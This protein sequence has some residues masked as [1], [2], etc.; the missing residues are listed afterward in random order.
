VPLAIV[1][2]E[3]ES[4]AV[5]MKPTATYSPDDNK[6]RLYPVARLDADTYKRVKD[7]G[8]SWAPKQE[9]FVAPM[10]TPEREE[11][12]IE[13]AGEIGDED[14]SLC[15]RAEQR[16]ERFEDYSD[17]RAA[18]AESA[19]DGVAAIADNIPFGQPILVGHHSEKRARK[20]AERIEN[21]MRR[22]VKMWET[23]KYWTDR[24]G[25]AIAHAK[26]LERP[27][28]RARRIKKIEAD[29]RGI[30]RSKAEAER[31]LRFWRG[32]FKLTNKETG[33]KI[34]FEISEANREKIL[35]FV[36]GIDGGAGDFNVVRK[37]GGQP[38]EG[39]S[40]WNVLQP[41]GERY[42]ACPSC[43]VEQC[44]QAA[45]SAFGPRI[46]RCNRWLA[47]YEN[48]LAYERAMLAEAGGTVADRV[49]PEVGG[50]CRCWCSPRSGWSLIQ[51]VNKVSVTLLDNWGNGG[52]DFTRTIPF[53]KLR[54]VMSRAQVDE[55]RALGRLVNETPRGFGLLEETPVADKSCPRADKSCPDEVAQFEAMKDTLKAG[56]KVVTVPQLFPTPP[57]LARQLAEMADIQANQRVLEPS[58]GTGALLSAILAIDPDPKPPCFGGVTAVEINGELAERLANEFPLTTV[59]CA[60]FLQC[61]GDLGKFD[62]IVMNPPFANGQ[63]IKHIEHALTL[64]KPG[65]RL[66]AICANGPRQQERLLPMATKWKELP[67]GS[68][69]DSGTEVNAAIL[70]IET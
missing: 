1:P 40:C 44:R 3:K 58:A 14:T 47:H 21:G 16:A 7:A 62:R 31:G 42:T 17:K 5:I 22:A 70:V 54:A 30:E 43:T 38:W 67:A 61:N 65:G 6:L 36:G 18:D 41:D 20:D 33:E 37:E 2:A 63:D 11:L 48:R 66:V 32:E 27:D 56:V 10:W 26:Y 39:W 69:S 34:A 25:R 9:L 35:R 52:R 49:L 8:F 46:E 23:S 51:K 68:F 19:R 53:D 28:V 59:R 57:D 12:L 64:L 13:L 4:H 55:A 15:D 50:A 45:E 60:D 29:K 24:A